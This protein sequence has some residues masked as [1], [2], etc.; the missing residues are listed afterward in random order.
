MSPVRVNKPKQNLFTFVEE[1]K[2]KYEAY[3]KKTYKGKKVDVLMCTLCDEDRK[4]LQEI[5][6]LLKNKKYAI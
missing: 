1:G 2:Y 3:T 4:L 6:S 5:K